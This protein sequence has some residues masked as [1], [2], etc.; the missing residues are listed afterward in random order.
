MQ[1]PIG[2]PSTDS[3]QE[4]SYFWDTH[5]LTDFDDQLEEVRTPTFARR[6]EPTVA[7]ALTR[8]EAAALKRL[9]E[10]EGV[11]EAN[12]VRTWIR[13]KLRASSSNKPLKKGMHPTP[14]KTRAAERQAVGTT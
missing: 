6:R 1:Q 9:A 4:L 2:I 7:I 12:L 13:Q 8:K 10:H 3:I 14:H 5:D 11:E